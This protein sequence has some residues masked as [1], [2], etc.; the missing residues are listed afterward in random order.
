MTGK[1]EFKSA[2][3][4]NKKRK[5]IRQAWRPVCTHAC[6]SEDLSVKDDRVESKD[7]SQ[8]QEMDCIMHSSIASAQP[9]EVV[10]EINVVTEL[11]VNVDGDTNLEGQSVPSGEK[12]SVKLNVS[13]HI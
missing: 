13:E 10:E 6:S 2:A 7:G 8:V 1:M 9:V 3:D 4:Q 11:S 12:F 5:T